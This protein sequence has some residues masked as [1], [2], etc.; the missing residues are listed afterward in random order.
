MASFNQ[1]LQDVTR[2]NTN[3]L[4]QPPYNNNDDESTKLTVIYDC[5]TRALQLKQ[6]VSS[7]IFAYFLGQLIVTGSLEKKIILREVSLHY[8]YAAIRIYYIFEFTPNRIYSTQ[9]ISLQFIRKM[10]HSDFQ[11]LVIEF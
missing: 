6:R 8:Y 5:L 10:K 4:Q 1:I 7:L 3:Q 9:F 2:E 11:R